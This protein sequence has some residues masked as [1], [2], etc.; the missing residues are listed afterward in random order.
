MASHTQPTNQTNQTN[1]TK[2]NQDIDAVVKEV[3]ELIS[4]TVRARLS[5]IYAAYAEYKE[6]HD[7]LLNIP[8]IQ[9][10]IRDRTPTSYVKTEAGMLDDGH[11]QN[12]DTDDKFDEALA[13]IDR[14]QSDVRALQLEN[15]ALRLQLSSVVAE[16]DY[17]SEVEN[18]NI[19]LIIEDTEVVG[20]LKLAQ[21]EVVVM[22][23]EESEA[24]DEEEEEE[25]DEDDDEDSEGN[26]QVNTEPVDDEHQE[27][28][29]EEEEEDIEETDGANED[30]PVEEECE[31]D[32][33]VE[34]SGE[35]EEQQD[36]QGQAEEVEESGDE[37]EEVDGEEEED[38]EEADD[39]VEDEEVDEEEEEEVADSEE[40]EV[41]EVEIKG[42]TY[43]TT[44]ET[45]GVIYDSLP[46]GDIGDE[47]G[48]FVKGKPV[49]KIKSK[50]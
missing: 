46:D 18:E 19:T 2:P 27:A 9:R 20:T 12:S 31:G 48:S 30:E 14:L 29:E 8:A 32:E 22:K 23:L 15:D 17:E 36:D 45:S 1:Q 35:E 40:V 7:A 16:S 5:G 42:K 33:E 39:E 24:D 10:A 26:A 11:A 43:F 6:T 28:E 4:G 25:D 37:E 34:E 13:M 41:F 47:V 21:P 38:I 50:V 49:F 3:S 44:D